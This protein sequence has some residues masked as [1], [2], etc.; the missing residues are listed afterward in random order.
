MPKVEFGNNPTGS[1]ETG[2]ADN[3]DPFE[4]DLEEALC[5]FKQGD[6]NSDILEKNA[7]LVMFYVDL[8]NE[9]IVGSGQ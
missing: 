1:G 8:E 2:F 4:D 5:V 9:Q 6:N 3:T 7:K